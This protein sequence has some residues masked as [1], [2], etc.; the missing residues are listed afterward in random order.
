MM[1]ELNNKVCTC[2]GDWCSLNDACEACQEA[3]LHEYYVGDTDQQR[4]EDHIS[5]IWADAQDVWANV[6]LSQDAQD[7]IQSIEDA[8]SDLPF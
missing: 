5:E 3:E 4:E 6:A 1:N 2:N 8:E 7:L